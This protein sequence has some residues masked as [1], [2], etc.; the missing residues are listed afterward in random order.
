MSKGQRL[1][2]FLYGTF[3]MTIAVDGTFHFLGVKYE[4]A[5]AM[6]VG[7]I[8]MAVP[9]VVAIIIQKAMLKERVI[10]PLGLLPKWSPWYLVALLLPAAVALLTLAIS[11]LFKGVSYDFHLTHLI[12]QFATS[13]PAA[14]ATIKKFAEF[15]V[16]PV[17]T[18]LLPALAA[19]ASVNAIGTLG[20][21]I[22]WRGFLFVNLGGNFWKRAAITGAIW[23]VWHTP[24][25]LMGHNKIGSMPVNLLATYAFCFLWAF[26]FNYLREASQSLLPCAVMHGTINALGNYAMQLTSGGT[27]ATVSCLG[28]AGLIALAIVSALV[29]GLDSQ[30]ALPITQRSH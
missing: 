18:M 8:T 27:Q 10:E 3:L 26:L 1:A 24:I 9:A 20:E 30:R 4:G 17:I 22:G 25:V 12:E 2:F 7:L 11:P 21:E 23:G 13:K 15:P 28:G 19:G 6:F 14:S 16:P 29:L 5:Q